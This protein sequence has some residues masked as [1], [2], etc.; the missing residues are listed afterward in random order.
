MMKEIPRIMI[1]LMHIPG[2]EEDAFQRGANG[3]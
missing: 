2:M 3:K 1:L